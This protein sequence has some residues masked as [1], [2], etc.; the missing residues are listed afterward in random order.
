MFYSSARPWLSSPL[1]VCVDERLSVV[2]LNDAAIDIVA[3]CPLFVIIGGGNAM[4]IE[5]REFGNITIDGK[6]YDHDVIIGLSG[7]VRKRQKKL[8]KKQYGISHIISKVEAKSVFKKGCDLII[9][10]AGHEGNVHLSPEARNYF[11]NKRCGVILQ[12]TP[13]AIRSFNHSKANKIGL[14]HVAC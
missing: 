8:S 1:T 14:M 5:G 11:E 13:E 9:I 10:G 2:S 6:T 7:K 4:R 12:P 3:H